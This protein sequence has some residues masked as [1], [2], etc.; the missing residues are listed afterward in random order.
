MKSF[1]L[2]F[3]IAIVADGTLVWARAAVQ[4]AGITECCGQNQIC[5]KD[6]PVCLEHQVSPAVN[7]SRTDVGESAAI[8]T[9]ITP[10]EEDEDEDY[11][12]KEEEGSNVAKIESSNDEESDECED[13]DDSGSDNE[14]ELEADDVQEVDAHQ[15]TDKIN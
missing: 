2:I 9:M 4:N 14:S 10:D 7:D 8:D 5:I 3:F 13:D 11:E 1:F 6:I 15:S 12:E